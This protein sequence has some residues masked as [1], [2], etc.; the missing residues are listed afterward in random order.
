MS[1]L[2]ENIQINPLLLKGARSR[3]RLKHLLSWGVVTITITAFV[4]LMTY[5][6]MTEQELASPQD[7]A[8]AVLPGIIVIQSILLMMFGTGAVAS[9]VSAERDE[10][11][12]DY[13]RM[14]PMSPTSKIIGYLFGLPAREYV[15][16]AITLPFVVVA[17]VVSGFSVL[18]LL[19]FYAVFFTSVWIYHMTGMVAGVVSKKPR[20][21][22]MM[23]MGLVAVLY[24]A[25]PNLSRVGITFFEF[26][27]IRP[28]FFGLL[29]QE[30]PESM[31]SQA[32][33][34]GIDSFRDVPLYWGM[35]HPTL[36]TL[37]VQGFMLAVMFS[38]VHRRW[39]DQA[40]HV[41]SKLGA[42]LVYVGVLV[43]L[44]GSVSAIVVND[45]AYRQIFGA[46]GGAIG[47]GRSPESLELLLI[48]ALMIMGGAY[49]LLISCVTPSRHTAAAGFRRAHKLGRAGLGANADA[50]SSLPL[51]LLMTLVTLAAGAFV[52]W[53]VGREGDYYQGGPSAGSAAVLAVSIAGVALFIQGVRERAGYLVFG[54]SMFLLWMIP[55]FA[56]MIMYAAF[57]AFV[58]GS[59]IGLPCPPVLLVFAIGQMLETTT[60]LSGASPDYLPEPMAAYAASIT[61]VGGVGY[62]LA[63][64]LAQGVRHRSWR[65]LRRGIMT[66]PATSTGPLPSD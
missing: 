51:A 41:F 48:I 50:A 60:P 2:A 25:L 49:L 35:V 46:F 42:L 21:A 16:F 61:L 58:P 47:A 44:I 34:T 15:L 52:L 12:L 17:V 20:M 36:Y 19:H 62:A 63:A 28:V 18:T 57:E 8:K 5:M 38:V 43:F 64:L 7:A 23:S 26:I 40:A 10:G 3:V 45:D 53:L 4:S 33:A 11:L 66:D 32:E 22:S 6:T 14:T 27:T 29:Q 55:F 1:V 31:R 65:S 9:G 30:L 54:V 24:F 37:M 59:Y 56:M 39:R 13:V